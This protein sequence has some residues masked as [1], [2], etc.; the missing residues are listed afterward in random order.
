MK[1]CI[2]TDIHNN[3]VAL[4]SVLNVAYS[5][6]CEKFICAGDIIGIGP[7]PEETVQR[8]M[9]IP[10]LIAVRGNHETYLL[11]SMPSQ[12]PNNEGMGYEEMEHHKWEHNR[13]S[14]NSILFLRNLPYRVDFCE[15][16]KKIS[17]MHYFMNRDNQY[18]NYRLSQRKNHLSKLFPS[19]EQDIVIFGH[20]HNRT[21]CHNKD[22]WFINSGSLGCPASEKNIARA[23]ILEITENGSI[24]V[25]NIDVQYNV[26][27]VLTDINR[28]NY[29]ASKEIKQIFFGVKD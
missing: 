17:V 25:H 21:I 22:K 9:Q 16:G 18:I 5:E 28:L 24:S 1:V 14:Q 19:K 2:L 4:E 29:P 13:L 26:Q 3:V 6:N 8:V 23:T 12:Y 20:D 27:K 15:C 11:E 10:N 7:Y